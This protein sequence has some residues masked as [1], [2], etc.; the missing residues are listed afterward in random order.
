MSTFLELKNKVIAKFGASD[1]EFLD[2]L[3]RSLN[4]TIAEINAE[5]PEAPHLQSTSTFTCTVGTS[6]VT[7]GI[8][9]DFDHQLN[10]Y[11][12]VSGKNSPP[13]TYKSRKEWNIDRPYELGDSEPKF[14]NIWNNTLYLAPKPDKA[15]TGT[16]DYYSFDSELT[17]DT[18]TA[19]LTDRYPRW[20]HLI[21]KG[22]VA[23]MNEFLESDDRAIDRSRADYEFSTKRFRSWIRKNFD[24]SPESS[25]IKGWRERRPLLLVPRQFRRF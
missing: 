17:N 15:Y 4:A 14:Y 3:N 8:P 6:A 21:F 16:L 18:D 11:I 19:K 13:L 25:R 9:S 24:K 7:S 1:S 2:E 12:S 10:A 20:E 5:N 22:T 23:K